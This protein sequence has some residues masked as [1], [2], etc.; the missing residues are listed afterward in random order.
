MTDWGREIEAVLP[1]EFG[2]VVSIGSCDQVDWEG[3]YG[4]AH[5]AHQV[6]TT[7]STRFAI[8]SGTKAFTALVIVSLLSEGALSLTSTARPLLGE[9]LPLVGDDVT[10]EHLLA[11]TS[12]IGDFIDHETGQLPPH[13]PGYRLVNTEDYLVAL[14]GLPPAFPAGTQFSYCNGGY[15]VL[16]LIAERVCGRGF[17]ELVEERVFGPAEM[18]ESAFFRLDA[19]PGYAAVGY[20]DDGRTNV[21]AA[22][23]RGNG[24]G[25]AYTTVSDVRRFWAALVAGR[26]VSAGW[27]Q[28]MISPQSAG[29]P[30]HRMHYGWGVWL[31]GSVVVL[32]GGD[33]GV[34]FRSAFEPSSRRLWTVASNTMDGA[35]PIVRRVRDLIF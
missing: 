17:H 29:P 23:V 13:V 16:A 10:V 35:A 30:A 27:V 26:I 11:H 32:D 33:H 5:R 1:A 19:L 24:D 21:F 20:L 31:D 2:G 22:P 28:Q 12:G 15:V 25:G 3:A 7:R 6:P 34:S 14:S 8:A 18:V 4:L 9:D